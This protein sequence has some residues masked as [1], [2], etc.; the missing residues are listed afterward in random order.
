MIEAFPQVLGKVV[1]HKHKCLIK[2]MLQAQH[3]AGTLNL[4]SASVS[5]IFTE[6]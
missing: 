6:D 4:K 3:E 1:K 2:E 5:T